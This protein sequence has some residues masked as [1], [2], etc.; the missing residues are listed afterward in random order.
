MFDQ[1]KDDGIGKDLAKE[2]SL[3]GGAV[4]LQ[5]LVE[6]LYIQKHGF[7]FIEFLSVICH[8]NGKAVRRNQDLVCKALLQE[9]PE[10]LP[11]LRLD[12]PFPTLRSALDEAKVASGIQVDTGLAVISSD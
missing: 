5:N 1:I 7:Q 12:P 2:A 9:S 3:N 11:K 10:L 6:F 8:C 4:R